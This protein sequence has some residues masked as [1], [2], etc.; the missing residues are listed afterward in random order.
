[1]TGSSSDANADRV[2]GRRRIVVAGAV[3]DPDRQTLLLAR[4][5]YPPEVAG[6]WELP[7]GKVEPGETTEAALRR[8]LR[9]ELGVDVSVGAALDERVPLTDDLVLVALAARIVDGTPRPVEHAA[10][11]WCD[12]AELRELADAGLLVPADSAWV[13]QLLDIL[14]T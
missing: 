9:E 14:A 11:R 12:A 6:L 3:I 1:M 10:L 13:P 8:E 2:A 7:G 4:R 5:R